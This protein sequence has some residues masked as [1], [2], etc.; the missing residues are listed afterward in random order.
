MKVGDLVTVKPARIGLYLIVD[1]HP[2]KEMNW[3]GA[4][5]V[6]AGRLWELHS[7]ER[8]GGPMYEKFIE[9]ISES[10]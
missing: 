8:R 4:N 5:G 1:S 10:Q 6:I 7:T 3:P 9:V 2:D